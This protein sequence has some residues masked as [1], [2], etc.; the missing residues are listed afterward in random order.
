MSFIDGL[1]SGLDTTSIVN[2]LMAIE[3][4]PQVALTQRRD[5]EQAARTEL[6][7]IRSDVSALRTLAADLRLPGGWDGII[8]TSSNDEAVSVQAGTS[9]TTST[10]SFQVTALATAASV[11]STAE[12]ATTDTAVNGAVTLQEIVNDVNSQDLGYTAAAV[13]TGTGYRLQLTAT[14][15][16]ADSAITVDPGI[17]GAIAFTTLSTGT[18]AEL[19][20]QGDNP[21][22]VVSSTNTFTELLPGVSVTVNAVTDTPVTV[23]TEP[24]VEGLAEK[25]TGLVDKMN[26]ILT[27]ISTSTNNGP[28]GPRAVLQ[29]N[30]D[31]RRAADELRNA[32]VAPVDDN[33][34]TS[35]GIVGIELTRE[36]TLTFNAEHFKEAFVSDPLSLTA[37][38]ADRAGDGEPGALDRLVEAAD[39]ATSVGE[40]YLYTAGESSDRRIDDY[41]RQIDAFERRM[42]LRESTLRRTYANLEVALGGLQQQSSWLTGQ[43][44]SLGGLQQ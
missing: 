1:A 19:T 28:T 11:Y 27:R 21:F 13:N 6:S 7:A 4:R 32:L 18:D 42:E 35:V 20:I 10:Y 14:E 24:D 15:T 34:F 30:Q 9:A 38:F 33:L 8:A 43:L 3:R 16:G 31:A 5:Q 37:L 36:G 23:T 17:F 22:T 25:V 44:A 12:Y 41:G 26:E 39:F 29:G 40:G 2:Q